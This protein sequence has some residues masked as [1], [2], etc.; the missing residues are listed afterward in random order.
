M[1][2]QFGFWLYG[3]STMAIVLASLPSQA[4]QRLPRPSASPTA[5]LVAQTLGVPVPGCLTRPKKAPPEPNL[6]TQFVPGALT[7]D[8]FRQQPAPPALSAEATNAPQATLD[9]VARHQPVERIALAHPTNFGE[10]YLLDYAGQPANREPIIVLHETVSSGPETLKLF[11][12]NHPKNAQQVSYHTL[13]MRDG[14]IYYLVPPDKRAFGA[15]TSVFSG[16]DGNESVRTN[17][18]LSASV[19]NFAYHISFVSP[20]DGRSNRSNHSGYTSAQYYSL[21]W[22]AAKTG[23]PSDRITTHQAVDRAGN[24]TD[25][26]SF[27]RAGFLSL[28]SLYPKT[29]EIVIGCPDQSQPFTKG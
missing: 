24:R 4:H 17:P 29:N 27:N 23:V 18:S 2:Q 7:L 14:T 20:P 15:G 25:P 9:Y 16:P 8:R 11:Q 6:E 26:R 12:T 21:A 5:G 13:I 28:L 19:N 3:L 10:R 22:L 1:K